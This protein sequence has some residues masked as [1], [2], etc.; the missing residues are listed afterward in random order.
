MA[1]SLSRIKGSAARHETDGELRRWPRRRIENVVGAEVEQAAPAACLGIVWGA[2]DAAVARG[3]GV[4]AVDKDDDDS[5][6]AERRI[7]AIFFL[8]KQ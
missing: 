2:A 8:N 1:L 4:V 7:V 6:D 5:V 3:R